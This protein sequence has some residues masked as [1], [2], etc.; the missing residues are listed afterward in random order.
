MVDRG[1]LDFQKNLNDIDPRI[2]SNAPSD[3]LSLLHPS[4]QPGNWDVICQGGKESYDHVGNRRFRIC[5]QN[6]LQAYIKAKSKHTRSAVV[7]CIVDAIREC[8]TDN[9]GGFVRRDLVTNRWYEVSDKM[10]REKVGHA[11][12]EAINRNKKSGNNDDAAAHDGRKTVTLKADKVQS[13]PKES[14]QVSCVSSLG[15]NNSELPS[16]QQKASKR[17]LSRCGTD[18]VAGTAD[19]TL[20]SL[21]LSVEMSPFATAQHISPPTSLTSVSEESRPPCKKTKVLAD[22]FP[23]PGVGNPRVRLQPQVTTKT[24]WERSLQE[25]NELF[26][27]WESLSDYEEDGNPDADQP[28]SSSKP[29]AK[30][31]TATTT[32]VAAAPA[33]TLQ[34]KPPG[35]CNIE[36]SYMDYLKALQ[37]KPIKEDKY[38][39]SSMPK[40]ATSASLQNPANSIPFVGS[41]LLEVSNPPQQDLP[42]QRTAMPTFSSSVNHYHHEGQ[43]K[44]NNNNVMM[45]NHH[46]PP[47]IIDDGG[48]PNQLDLDAGTFLSTAGLSNLVVDDDIF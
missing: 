25:S 22:L 19:S 24:A 44:R 45:I 17:P 38:R 36:E 11:L 43:Q 5:I 9:V 10:A 4:F 3:K 16:R 6:N 1:R 20:T 26:N 32:V 42:R 34:W 31:H 21:A 29:A 37:P 48:E 47:S 12:R 46:I 33:S 41:P 2:R 30:C 14:P 35:A 15:Q 39:K 18:T 40:A 27:A 13:I 23:P 7:S 8:R 28:V